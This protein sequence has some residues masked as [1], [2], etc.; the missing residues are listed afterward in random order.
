MS[1][2]FAGVD[3]C[4]R[5]LAFTFL[6]VACHREPPPPS[7]HREPVVEIEASAPVASVSVADENE[8]PP[9]PAGCRRAIAAGARVMDA[10]LRALILDGKLA[11]CL[12][13]SFTLSSYATPTS[14]VDRFV[15]DP[16][17]M[18]VFV[19]LSKEGGYTDHCHGFAA[20]V[21]VDKD[22]IVTEGVG[23]ETIDDCSPSWLKMELA[24]LDG[25]RALLFPHV[26]STGEDG[27]FEMAWN[28]WLPDERG[29]LKSVG[30]ITS[31]RSMGNGSI[32]SGKWFDSLDAKV[33]DAGGLQIEEHW[34]L[35]RED[36]GAGE[37]HGRK[38]TVVRRYALD[39]GKLV[40]Q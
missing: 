33:L 19:S 20:I 23:P 27:D 2:P 16:T 15:A 36:P 7:V 35:V 25:H 18:A 37:L 3:P 29:A 24:M 4:V 13:H 12:G 21:R 8:A 9:A 5:R 6:L 32:S 26:L 14:H 11:D 31:T 40:R 22:E 39:G 34:E 1:A 38:K 17:H 10:D 30:K 28:V